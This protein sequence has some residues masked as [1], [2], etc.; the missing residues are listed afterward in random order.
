[1]ILEDNSRKWILK[2][3]AQYQ[4]LDTGDKQKR[5]FELWKNGIDA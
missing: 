1:M 3:T 4:L 5:C 2:K